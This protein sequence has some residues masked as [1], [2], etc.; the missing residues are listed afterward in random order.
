MSTTDKES[1]VAGTDNR[2]LMWK[3]VDL[4]LEIPYLANGNESIHDYFVRFH[5]LI[6]DM[7]ITK[8][9]ILAHQRNTK[10][11]NNLPSYWSKYVT[12][13]KNSQDI[14][15]VSYVNL[16]TH[17][18]SYEQHAM[19]TLSKMNQSSG[20]NEAPHA[21]AA[22]MANQLGISTREGT[23]NDTNFHSKEL[24][25]EQAY[26]LPATKVGSNQ[27]KPAQQFVLTRPAK[28]QVNSHLKT[29]KSC[30][31]EFDE[32]KE[33]LQG[34]DNIIGMLKA[35]INNMKDVST[36]PSLSTLEI[37]N[38]K[39]KEELTAVRIKNDSLRDEMI[40]CHI[41]ERYSRMYVPSQK[42]I[43]M[44]TNSSL[45]RKEIVTVVDLSNVPVNLPIGIKS[46]PDV[47]KSMSKSD[48][49]IHKN[50]PAEVIQSPLVF[51]FQACSRQMITVSFKALKLLEKFIVG[52][53]CNGDPRV[54]FRKTLVS[55]H[56]MKR[57]MRVESI[58]GKKYIL[59]IVNDYT[60]FGWVRFLRT[61][62][63]TPEVIKKFIILM[64]RALNA[65]VRYLRID[66]GMEFNGVVKRWNRT[67]MEAAL[68][69]LIFEKA[70]MFLWAEAVPTTCYILN[71]SLIH[72]L[73][74]KTY[75]E[76]LKGKKPKVKYFWVF[77]SLCYPTNAYGDLGK[78]KAKVD[79][80]IF[81]GYAPTKK[82][83]QIYNK[84]T[85]KIQ[86]TVHVMF[87]ELTE[88]LTY[89]QSSTG[90]RL[91]SMALEHINAGS[92]LSELFQPLYDEDEEF[93]PKVQ[94]HLVNVAP[95]RAHEIAPDSP[96]TTTI[97]EDA[98]AATTITLPSQTSPP[99][100]SVDENLRITLLHLSSDLHLEFCMMNL[101]QMHHFWHYQ[102]LE[103]VKPKNFKEAVQYPSW[104]V[105][106][107]RNSL[108]SNICCMGT[109]TDS[110]HSS[111]L[112]SNGV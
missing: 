56:N 89:V 54:A 50:L 48:K 45:P 102:F 27:S 62:D 28:S 14:S 92:D 5:K 8:I 39:L 61:K 73:H 82:A 1:I 70:P 22:F 83:Y 58:N 108:S 34:K 79:I 59:V 11:L 94:P 19:K 63:E 112:D 46:V 42:R 16:Y 100:S 35:H 76:L 41:N 81:V 84:R 26:W 6:N 97:T 98:P 75:Y 18:K 7:K 20:N 49:K 2:P 51:G 24:T 17:L 10:F 101:I 23:S 55:I 68:T 47:S 65:T 13:V 72:T 80:G 90:L 93:P 91:N 111:Q 71:R 4:I 74:G 87:D 30:F 12:I 110:L 60:R 52:Q 3:N 40:M 107:K 33:Q 105:P 109:C 57:P 103:N 85:R 44:E 37:E 29:L 32:L 9:Q 77:G 21:V 106:C 104:I 86:V 96:S 64:Q 95:P 66:N 25:R 53:F 78:M 36:G 99:D 67:L 88:G 15:N 43:N 38:T 69:I 31:P